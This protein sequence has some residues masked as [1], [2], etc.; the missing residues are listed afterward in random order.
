[1]LKGLKDTSVAEG[2]KD[3][4]AYS[5]FNYWCENSLASLN[6]ALAEEKE[7]V[8]TLTDTVNGE[9][10]EVKS[11]KDD[12]E[13]VQASIAAKDLSASKAKTHSEALTAL[14]TKNALALSN[15]INAV[16]GALKAVSGAASKSET[17]LLL[18]RPDVKR[19][20]SL[21]QADSTL[22]DD[23]QTVGPEEEEQDL[24]KL[25]EEVD[26]EATDDAPMEE[27][28]D[29]DATQEEEQDKPVEADADATTKEEDVADVA[30]VGTSMLAYKVAMLEGETKEGQQAARVAATKKAVTKVS[31]VATKKAVQLAAANAAA[32]VKKAVATKPAVKAMGDSNKHVKVYNS[33]TDKVVQLLM[34]LKAEFMQDKQRLDT[35]QQNALN[36]YALAKSA[37]TAAQQ[38]DAKS[39]QNSQRDLAGTKRSLASDDGQLRSAKSDMTADT[40]GKNS[41][42]EKCSTGKIEFERRSKTRSLELAAL[43][44]AVGILGKA[45]G[46]RTAAPSNPMAP[47]KPVLFF[48]LSQIHEHAL[49]VNDPKME[50]VTLLRKA[51]KQTHSTALARL[52]VEVAAHLNGPFNKVNGIIKSMIFRLMGEQTSEDDHKH[53]CDLE[54]SKTAEM[55]SNNQD[56]VNAAV[57]NIGI[58][59]SAVGKL[60][61][62]ITAAQ[63]KVGE[64]ITFMNEATEIRNAG[65]MEN[66]LAIKDAQE[67]QKAITNAISVLM[68][69][70]K[71]TG[72]VKKESWELIQ[73]D[74]PVNL[75][76]D[77]ALWGSAYTG[78]SKG[79]AGILAM[80]KTVGADFATMYHETEG[81]E[82]VDQKEYAKAMSENKIEKA[83][84]SKDIEMKTGEKASRVGRISTLTSEKKSAESA[85]DKTQKY[86]KDLQD[87]CVTTGSGD[88][89][90]KRKAARDKEITAVK[91]SQQVLENAFKK[92]ADA[93]KK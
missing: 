8:S 84:R 88:T 13:V 80:L 10:K 59:T 75:P 49:S 36:N 40:A 92:Q 38:A 53:W 73:Q 48:Q 12:I 55:E 16:G 18:Q 29:T 89:Y 27:V 51:G 85:L 11:T 82:V 28:I 45:T 34:D 46:V 4:Q 47:A 76:K 57:A 35:E 90:K 56:D 68:S 44:A 19:M 14:Y 21:I 83:R 41:V 58:E 26:A 63:A 1:M 64:I 67:G 25:V 33:K 62:A 61:G 30:E 37:Q 86:E 7:S 74:A 32:G 43:D 72:A 50:A 20:L 69:F 52:S 2:Q 15:S 54:L 17:A 39:L 60:S 22:A 71:S 9:I 79:Q 31:L 5:K 91:K 42:S 24:D 78:A 66:K 93:G 6:A 87:A 23:D 77:P 70:Y 3:D 81:Q 65:K